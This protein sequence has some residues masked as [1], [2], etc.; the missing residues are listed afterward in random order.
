MG[1]QGPAL[2]SDR[3]DADLHRLTHFGAAGTE[4]RECQSEGTILRCDRQQDEKRHPPGPH[5]RQDPTDV[6][7]LV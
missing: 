5:C 1:V 3:A 4:K 2:L 7:G 6:Q